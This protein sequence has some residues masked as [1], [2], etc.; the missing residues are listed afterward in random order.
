MEN[1]NLLTLEQAEPGLLILSLD[2]P[3]VN[4]LGYELADELQRALD[5]LAGDGG[6]RC[7][8]V[9]SAGKHFCAGADLKERKSMTLDEVRIF[10]PR[11][12]TIC[13][14]LAGLPFPSIAA[15]RGAAAGGDA[16]QQP[17]PRLRTAWRRRRA[18][19]ASGP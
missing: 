10:V 14:S 19:L 8:I 18:A 9:R 17:D 2:R 15:V 5:A 13:N 6:A 16:R 7:L 11:L 12:M 1:F 3:L 4:A